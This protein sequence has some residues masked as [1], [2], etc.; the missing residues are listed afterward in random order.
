MPVFLLPMAPRARVSS[1]V[2]PAAPCGALSVIKRKIKRAKLPLIIRDIR[3]D[4]VFVLGH[5]MHQV[6]N[7][8]DLYCG[9]PTLKHQYVKS[10]P[11]KYPAGDITSLN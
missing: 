10:R 4:A 9:T 2:S 8:G 3:S 11:R 6:Q 7:M 1:G 5:C